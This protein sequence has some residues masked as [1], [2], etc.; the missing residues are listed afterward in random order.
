[1]LGT[2]GT[3][4][5]ISTLGMTPLTSGCDVPHRTVLSN[6]GKRYC[7]QRRHAKPARLHAIRL[8]A[9][10]LRWFIE[11]LLLLQRL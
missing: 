11:E 4:E 10:V 7:A 8:A 6:T 9:E 2:S 3:P 5:G 1:M